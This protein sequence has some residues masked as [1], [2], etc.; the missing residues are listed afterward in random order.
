MVHN[1][2]EY[3]DMQLICEAYDILSR[4][5][6]LPESEIADIFTKW[7]TGASAAGL[8]CCSTSR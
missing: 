1:G 8:L 5:L 7:N 4:G 6:G 3:G 2:I